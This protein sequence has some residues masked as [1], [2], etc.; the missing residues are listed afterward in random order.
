[1]TGVLIL[2]LLRREKRGFGGIGFE[3]W[4]VGALYVTAIAGVIV[5]S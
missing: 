1:M 4:S 2:G 3:G 5:L